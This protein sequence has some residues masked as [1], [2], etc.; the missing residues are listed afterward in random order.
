MGMAKRSP[1]A[2]VVLTSCCETR[3]GYVRAHDLP[4][5]ASFFVSGPLGARHRA[6]GG[7]ERQEA[8]AGSEA[9]HAPPAAAIA[10]LAAAAA[11]PRPPCDW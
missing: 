11:A 2:N 9:G 4:D 8:V 5:G 3:L 1:V 6:R 7:F 10:W